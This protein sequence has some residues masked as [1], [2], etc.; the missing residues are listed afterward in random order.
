[1]PSV[2]LKVE[3]AK[4]CFAIDG[5]GSFGSGNFKTAKEFVDVTTSI[6]SLD[7]PNQY[8]AVQF[9]KRSQTISLLTD[10]LRQFLK[11]LRN[12]K[13]LSDNGTALNA[14]IAMCDSILSLET[15]KGPY[16]MVLLTDG[17][18]NFGRD[19]VA[20]ANRFRGRDPANKIFAVEL[21]NSDIGILK[22][23][24]G[25]SGEVLK[26]FEYFEFYNKVIELTSGHC[27]G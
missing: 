25:K 9:G 19:P 21:G 22:K 24:V 27:R 16:V 14:G 23:I 2:R 7:E 26:I 15:S 17:R 13:H 12:E 11:V 20:G 3:N 6:L 1:M 4:I 18:N 5:S 8:S 10:D